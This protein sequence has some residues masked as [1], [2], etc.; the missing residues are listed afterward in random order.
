VKSH[1]I[2]PVILLELPDKIASIGLVDRVP[3]KRRR[4]HVV[5]E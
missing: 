5:Q 1:K 3:K 4:L 2:N